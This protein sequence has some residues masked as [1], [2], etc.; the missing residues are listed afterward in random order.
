MSMPCLRYFKKVPNAG[1]AFARAL[2]ERYFSSPLVDC[3]DPEAL[4][5]N[6]M[7]MGSILQWAGPESW[8]CGCG[9]I[10]P[11][12]RLV[13]PPRYIDCVRGHR[14]AQ[15][16]EKQGIKPPRL[17]GDPGVLAPVLFPPDAADDQGPLG[18]TRSGLIP[19]YVD[20]DTPWIEK[21]RREG[22]RVIDV[23]A[24]LADYFA[25]LRSCDVILSSSLHGIIFAH[26]YGLP[27][28]WIKISAR[29]IGDGYKFTDYFS[30]LPSPWRQVEALEVRPEDDPWHLAERAQPA[31]LSELSYQVEA[32]LRAT[33]RR[34]EDVY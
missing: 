17:R 29:V 32:A 6:L 23:S 16:L 12:D 28:L 3:D 4:G 15:Q 8:I 2:A 1:D 34:L 5:P 24:T 19:H 20:R 18:R 21:W 13:T 25:A 7:L 31:D 22:Y 11:S 27:A 14:T 9:F 30:T 26:A 33:A 10:T